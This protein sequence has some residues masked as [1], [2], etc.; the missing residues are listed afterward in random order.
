MAAVEK[1]P[2]VNGISVGHVVLW[3]KIHLAT[4][5]SR[6][7]EQ[8]AAQ[9]HA[10]NKLTTPSSSTT[11][12]ETSRA[13][14]R[15]HNYASLCLQLGVLLMQLNDTE[16]EGDGE[17]CIMTWK[18]LMLYFRSRSPGKKYAFEAMRLITYV[19]ALYTEKMAFRISHGQFVNLRCDAGNNYVIMAYKWR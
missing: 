9:E 4:P 1:N 5:R 2:C 15:L 16:K 18:L 8:S 17:R 7:S 14:D 19:K 12:T 3:P 11:S 13:E 10:G 6:P